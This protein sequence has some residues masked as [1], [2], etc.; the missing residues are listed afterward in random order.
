MLSFMRMP[1][2]GARPPGRHRGLPL[3][4]ENG[5]ALLAA[6]DDSFRTLLAV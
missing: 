2:M 6:I 4:T 5:M 1:P 3:Q